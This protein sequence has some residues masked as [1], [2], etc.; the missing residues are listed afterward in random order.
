[1]SMTLLLVGV[2]GVLAG[3]HWKRM[4]QSWRNVQSA[5][6]QAKGRLPALK[7]TRARHTGTAFWYAVATI[8]IV[9][10]VAKLH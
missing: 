8:L 7:E 1:M 4:H 2:F 3:W 10:L 6:A 9:V 5:I